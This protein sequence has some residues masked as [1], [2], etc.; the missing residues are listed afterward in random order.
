MKLKDLFSQKGLVVG[1]PPVDAIIERAEVLKP[2]KLKILYGETYDEYGEP[3]DSMKHYFF[4]ANLAYVLEKEGISAEPII[5]I[6]DIATCR[7][8]PERLHRKLM[9]LG[10]KRVDFAKKV[11]QIYNGNLK[12]LLMSELEKT[13]E[14]HD[15][16]EAVKKICLNDPMLKKMIEKTIPPSKLEIERKKG[17]LY[18]L[19]EI[20]IIGTV[21][22]KV[23]PPREQLYDQIST[24]LAKH[25]RSR[26][27]LSIYLTP[28]YPVGVQF[29]YFLSH[30]EIEKHGITAYKAGSKKMQDNRII[31]GRTSPEKVKKLIDNTFIPK[32]PDMPNPLLD[33]A[34][35]AEMAK[36]RIN[37]KISPIRVYEEFYN[38]NLSSSELK[39][40]TINNLIEYILSQFSD[41]L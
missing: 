10:K 20:T 35:I 11:S 17:F 12:I 22:V 34:I 24:R 41:N 39:E 2:N 32:Y 26:E 14:F 4:V 19:E 30:P 40:K 37:K 5:L 31:I 18:S 33:L 23:G 38:G 3:I 25:F 13:K 9:D 16:F 7:N 8:A 28:S 15:K 21:D 27:L 36:Q 1:H 6:G 29:D